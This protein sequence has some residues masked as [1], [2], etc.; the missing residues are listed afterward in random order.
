[1]VLLFFLQSASALLSAPGG[2]GFALQR[3][4]A[5]PAVPILG[6]KEAVP[7]GRQV[8]C[9]RAL[10]MD[11]IQAVG[12]DLDYTLAE[13][14]TE[15]DLLAYRG[16]IRK[17]RQLGYPKE[18]EEFEYMPGAYQRGLLIDKRRGTDQM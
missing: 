14:K 15:F 17:L 5:S 3:A 18:I 4:S 1:M 10:N 13:Y 6:P 2:R 11:K 16:A 12:F 8:F 9:N 7:L